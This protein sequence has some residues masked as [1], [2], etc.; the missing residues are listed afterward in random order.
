MIGSKGAAVQGR[1]RE[2]KKGGVEGRKAG[3]ADAMRPE[4]FNWFLCEAF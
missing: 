2:P 1:M 3:A 4:A